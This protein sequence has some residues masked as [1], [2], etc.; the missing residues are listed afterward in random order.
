MAK[1]SVQA[2][3]IPADS[4]I[5]EVELIDGMGP[6]TATEKAND[7][8]ADFLSGVDGT[9]TVYIY[10][11][12]GDGRSSLEF[13]DSFPA[14]Q[15]NPENTLKW[16]RDK[17][18]GGV[19]RIQIRSKG[20]VLSNKLINVASFSGASNALAP[21]QRGGDPIV[22]ALLERMESLENKLTAKASPMDQLKEMASMI[23]VMREIMGPQAAPVSPVNQLKDSLAMLAQIK[24]LSDGLGGNVEPPS[25]VDKLLEA[26]PQLLPA[27]AT[28]MAAGGRKANPM[29]PRPQPQPTP[30]A[31]P[32]PER[33]ITPPK[34]EQ[35]EM[36]IEGLT[37]EQNEQFK[38]FIGK[39]C[40]AASFG[41]DPE[42]IAE[43]ICDSVAPEQLEAMVKLPDLIH[44]LEMLDERVTKH[45]AW[46]T[47]VIEWVKWHLEIPSKFDGEEEETDDGEPET[48][49]GEVDSE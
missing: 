30:K 7:E 31:N 9:A 48:L 40:M 15:F 25:M 17:C 11:Q 28:A 5:T 24:D 35:D 12:P 41:A 36:S 1:G 45:K 26:L 4:E 3:F 32:V 16:L 21:T 22:M 2:Q 34:Q 33:D 18:G 19:F 14:D 10:R 38:D 13:V 23:A 46:F 37:P 42:K 43:T 29:P 47:D 27:V 39:G 20:R 8:W 49:N 44:R 6:D